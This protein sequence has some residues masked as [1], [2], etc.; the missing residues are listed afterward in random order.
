MASGHALIY[1]PDSWLLN[2]A[3]DVD[4]GQ[5]FPQL[6]S[7][8]SKNSSVPDVEG[9][10]LWSDNTNMLFYQWGGQFQTSPENPTLYIYDTIYNTW[11]TT[12]ADL[13]EISRIAY[14][15][16]T[17]VE[18]RAEGYYYGGWLSNQSIAGWS[19]PR[20]AS[21]NII[22]YD[23]NAGTFSN[24]SGPDNL[25]R[26]EG[27]MVFLP[28]SDNGL[29][30]YFGGVIDMG[31]GSAVGANM[32]VSSRSRICSRNTDLCMKEI[33]IYDLN[34][35]KW[36]NQT[37]TGDVPDMRGKFCAGATWPTD[38]SS[39]NMYEPPGYMSDPFADLRL[40][41]ST[42][43]KAIRV[44][45]SLLMTSIS[46]LFLRSNGLNGIP[47]RQVQADRIMISPVT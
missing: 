27:A 25:G 23:M 33:W 7:N 19:G 43:A 36:Y 2:Q 26:A 32:T 6:Y 18:Q 13:S 1:Y 40:V 34:S 3:L 4:N 21:S 42:A 24:S 29:L 14:G 5:G 12:T 9:G 10:I 8:L 45:M 41:I 28:A 17:T 37:A 15:A 47:R 35:E 46:S 38:Q 16:G 39:Y 20:I 44:T 30:I 22:K 11:N 31:N